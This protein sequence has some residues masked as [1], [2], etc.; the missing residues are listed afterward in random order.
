MKPSTPHS[1][2]RS[3][4]VHQRGVVLVVA[5]IVMAV[6]A[7]TAGTAIRRVTSQDLIGSN[8]RAR[9]QALQAA[10][11]GLRY[12]EA[13]VSTS[14]RRG[15]QVALAERIQDAVA[16]NYLVNGQRPQRVWEQLDNW[17][18]GGIVIEVPATYAI[19]GS[20]VDYNQRPS[21]I[22]E[23]MSLQSLATDPTAPNQFEAYLITARGFSPDFEAN[24]G[25]TTRGA[26]VWVQSS[27]QIT[28]DL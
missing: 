8:L 15:E 17:D 16:T 5:L 4:R 24:N 21:C 13:L 19:D 6:I 3:S 12:C 27:V 18:D 10:E 14:T 1:S 20:G 2:A 26:E 25:V 7:I 28:S 9:S 23:R 22:I 11:S